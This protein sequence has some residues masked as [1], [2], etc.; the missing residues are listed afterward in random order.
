MTG[1]SVPEWVGA[2][3]DTVPPP[4][5]RVRLFEEKGGRCHRCTRK[6]LVGEYWVCE[7]LIALI[8]WRATEE[9]PHGNRES[10]LDLTCRNC[11][12]PKNAEDVA[13]KSEVATI[14]K[15]HILPREKPR[16][17]WKRKLN[18]EVVLR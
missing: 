11:I 12:Q 16:S 6:I 18:G 1:R 9:A 2:N 14:R 17:K 8:N 10:N 3:P 4:R 7:H 13:E 15:K 5:V